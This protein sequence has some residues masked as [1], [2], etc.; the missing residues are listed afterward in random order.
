MGSGQGTGRRPTGVKAT[1]DPEEEYEEDFEVVHEVQEEGAGVDA[2][3][4][5]DTRSCRIIVMKQVITSGV[6]RCRTANKLLQRW[7]CSGLLAQS[8]AAAWD[9]LGM[10]G[11]AFYFKPA[12]VG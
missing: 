9:V 8:C 11:V 4:V 3:V 10:V 2:P 1:E 7:R 5:D 12:G 6:S